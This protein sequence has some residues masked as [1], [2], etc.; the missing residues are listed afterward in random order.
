MKET[1]HE[2]KNKI[3]LPE[4]EQY[5]RNKGKHFEL[6]NILRFLLSASA[7]LFSSIYILYLL[8]S[9]YQ[10]DYFYQNN[11]TDIITFITIFFGGI[12][13]GFISFEGMIDIFKKKYTGLAI[14]KQSVFV[15]LWIYGLIIGVIF[16][17]FFLLFS[18]G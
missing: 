13:A 17:V 6:L 4:N 1:I 11:V 9:I 8:Y 5:S 2:L 14:I 18:I 12:T 16:L 3:N 15:L 7:I 10:N